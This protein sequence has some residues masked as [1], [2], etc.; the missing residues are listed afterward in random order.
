MYKR[1][2]Q[3]HIRPTLQISIYQ[4]LDEKSS[5]TVCTAT[6]STTPTEDIPTVK[7]VVND[8][9][10]QSLSYGKCRDGFKRRVLRH[11]RWARG[12]EKNLTVKKRR[13]LQRHTKEDMDMYR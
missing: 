11:D 8:N 5:D 4:Y 9:T 13:S 12:W 10:C 6:K 1:Q 3:Y 7:Y 2:V